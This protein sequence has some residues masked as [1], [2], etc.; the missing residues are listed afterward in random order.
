MI[1]DEQTI[2]A[3][4][5]NSIELRV[6]NLKHSFQRVLLQNKTS[7]YCSPEEIDSLFLSQA[8]QDT[9]IH[10]EVK[11]NLEQIKNRKIIGQ[12]E[13]KM[14]QMTISKRDEKK[15]KKKV[16]N[17]LI[18]TMT[19]GSGGT[20]EDKMSILGK[21]SGEMTPMAPQMQYFQP[22]PMTAYQPSDFHND[23]YR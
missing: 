9:R 13:D 12:M 1:Y 11:D 2:A 8:N 6:S 23:P 7:S 20:N 22:R 17:V 18:G 5:L 14:F 15:P 16:E 3:S 19:G 21:R 10:S 4:Q